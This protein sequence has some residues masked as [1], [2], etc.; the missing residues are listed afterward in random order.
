MDKDKKL[1]L[2]LGK[3]F[4]NPGSDG[5]PDSKSVSKV[6][7][8]SAEQEK[9]ASNSSFNIGETEANTEVFNPTYSNN[10]PDPEYLKYLENFLE[11]VNLPG[12]DYFELLKTV[13]KMITGGQS[14]QEAIKGAIVV[15]TSMDEA[16]TKEKIIET[17]SNYKTSLNQHQSDFIKDVEVRVKKA[18]STLM[19]NKKQLEEEISKKEQDLEDFKRQIGILEKEISDSQTKLTSFDKKISQVKFSEDSRRKKFKEAS[20]HIIKTI[21]NDITVLKNIS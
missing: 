1:N 20:D 12:F 13:N 7:Q 5:D 14:R 6:E 2:N 21:N 9:V 19:T 18:T 17:A 11:K 10:A 8:G 4:W 15:I 3:L 16:V